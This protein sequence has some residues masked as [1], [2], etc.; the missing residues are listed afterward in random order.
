MLMFSQ[1]K[2]INSCANMTWGTT[3]PKQPWRNPK[4]LL[5]EHFGVVR[6]LKRHVKPHNLD[7]P[8]RGTD[9]STRLPIAKK[10]TENMWPPR[11]SHSSANHLSTGVYIIIQ[12]FQREGELSSIR[13]KRAPD[14]KWS[15]I[16]V[17]SDGKKHLS[18]RNEGIPPCA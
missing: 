18:L 17:Y 4:A 11:T 15:T 7:S 14:C 6:F 2:T 8:L 16:S 13:N 10:K 9:N 1:G 12:A 3:L 5:A